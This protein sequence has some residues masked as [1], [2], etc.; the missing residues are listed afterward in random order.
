MITQKTIS[1]GLRK[2]GMVLSEQ[3]LRSIH[4]LLMSLAQIE[5]ESFLQNETKSHPCHAGNEPEIGRDIES[6]KNIAA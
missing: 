4:Q 2:E 3:E 6:Q 5:Y 1:D